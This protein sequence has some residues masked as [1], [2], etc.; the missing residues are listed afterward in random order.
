MHDLS[1]KRGGAV[2]I[3]TIRGSAPVIGPALEKSARRHLRTNFVKR[4]AECEIL[5]RKEMEQHKMMSTY[6]YEVTTYKCTLATNLL[7][8]H[9]MITSLV[10]TL[11]KQFALYNIKYI[12]GKIQSK[13]YY[14]Q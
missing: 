6:H 13:N 3:R 9:T 12:F 14:V 8:I 5:L 7:Q 2:P 1:V 10:A 11:H 4:R